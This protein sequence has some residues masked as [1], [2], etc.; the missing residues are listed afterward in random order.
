GG[1]AAEEDGERVG[2]AT[3]EEVYAAVELPWM[4]PELR[5]DRG[6]F[7][8]AARGELPSLVRVEDVR[9]DLHMHSTWSDGTASILEMARA[10]R[11]RGYQYMAVTDHSRAVTVAG[12][13]TPER[14]REQWEEVARVQEEMGEDFRIFRGQ[15][16]DI[17]KD[18][19]LDQPDDILE[20]LDLVVVSVHSFMD[21]DRDAMTR[22]VLKALSHPRVDIL[23][24]PTG[25]LL[26][27]REGYDLD[28][29]AVLEVA[30]ERD[31]AVEVNAH[32]RRLDLNDLN[33]RR[34]RDLGVRVVVNSDAHSVEGLDVMRFGVDQARRG[35]LA[36]GEVVNCLPH[37]QVSAWLGRQR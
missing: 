30:R 23:A 24:H 35:W 9:G 29:E 5:E 32:P 37:R 20:G 17:L 7:E 36:A 25:R 15:E 6:E 27:R 31:I 21:M 8:A 12:G 10:C 3:E 22:R 11:D 4:E 26:N 16:V 34:A 33:L 18:G 28:V 2:G 14:V 13:L 19:S 1:A